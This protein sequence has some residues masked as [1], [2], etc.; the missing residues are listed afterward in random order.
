MCEGYLVLVL[1]ARIRFYCETLFLRKC[2]MYEAFKKGWDV[3]KN[4]HYMVKFK[5]FQKIF[6]LTC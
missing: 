2:F 1:P 4:A 5:T 6:N 3:L